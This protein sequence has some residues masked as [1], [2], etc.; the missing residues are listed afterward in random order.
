MRGIKLN[1]LLVLIVS[2]LVLSIAL[3]YLVVVSQ[4]PKAS[5][6][7]LYGPGDFVTSTQ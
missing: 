2:S 4:N 6:K 5:T 3:S 7:P 1:V